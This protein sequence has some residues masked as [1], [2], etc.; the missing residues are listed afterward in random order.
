V[1]EGKEKCRKNVE[2][3]IKSCIPN[4]LGLC[5]YCISWSIHFSDQESS[6][7]N[8]VIRDYCIITIYTLVVKFENIQSST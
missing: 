2:Y 5:K 6:G 8:F 3:E 4:G 7:W 1:I